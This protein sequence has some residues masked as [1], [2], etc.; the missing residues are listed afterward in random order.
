[1][2]SIVDP[3]LSSTYQPFNL[4][5]PFDTS[6]N[7]GNYASGIYFKDTLGIGDAQ[8]FNQVMALVNDTSSYRG[9]L[10]LG[11]QS[12]EAGSGPGNMSTSYP[13]ILASMQNQGLINVQAYSVWFDDFRESS[14]VD[15]KKILILT[16]HRIR[17][18]RTPLRRL[19][20]RQIL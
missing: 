19:R 2:S 15:Y 8:V 5:G 14:S 1:M 17:D 20:F 6:Y 3:T 10:G 9:I 11:L 16:I 13:T 12:Q 7:D 4:S 18:G